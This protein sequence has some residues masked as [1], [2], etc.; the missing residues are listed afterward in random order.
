MREAPSD[1]SNRTAA[2]TTTSRARVAAPNQMGTA[3][4]TMMAITAVTTRSRSATGSRT[5]PT[6]DT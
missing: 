3:P 1:A 6:V 4:W 5:I 2:D